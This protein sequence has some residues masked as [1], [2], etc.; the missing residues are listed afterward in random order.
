MDL[1]L[2]LLCDMPDR[3]PLRRSHLQRS[4]QRW[5][6]GRPVILA[7]RPLCVMPDRWPLPHHHL[8]CSHQSWR[9]GRPV[10]LA[11]RLPCD[12]SVRWPLRRC[13]LR[14]SHRHLRRGRP[15]DLSCSSSAQSR[16]HGA[17][18]TGLLAEQGLRMPTCLRWKIRR[19]HSDAAVLPSNAGPVHFVLLLL[20]ASSTEPEAI[21]G[22]RIVGPYQSH[23]N[24]PDGGECSA[25]RS[26]PETS[27]SPR[28]RPAMSPSERTAQSHRWSTW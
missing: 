7:L 18:S 3:W 11:L 2:F 27:S 12:M 15:M 5:R 1:A 21:C 26:S 13:R 22:F 24:V 9:G 25:A 6:G 4:H 16:Y 14:C 17:V 8:Q 20:L 23:L 19:A 10:D 28:S